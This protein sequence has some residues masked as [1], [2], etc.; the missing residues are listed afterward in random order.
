MSHRIV[1]SQWFALTDLTFVMLSGAIGL[2]YPEP[3]FWVIL[4]ALLPWGVRVLAGRFPFQRT[5]LDWPIALFLITAWVGYW[6]AYDKTEA[7]NKVCFIVLSILLYY[8]LS[9]QPRRNLAWVGFFSFLIGLGVSVYF[10]L[11]NEFQSS[12]NLALGWRSIRPQVEWTALHPGY[13]SGVLIITSLVA[14]YGISK[15]RITS[16]GPQL[17]LLRVV[18]LSGLGFMVWMLMASI[19]RGLWLAIAGAI[20]AW[21]MWKIISQFTPQFRSFYSFLVI[22]LLGSVLIFVLMFP[23]GPEYAAT[24]ENYGQSTRSEL[25]L[26]GLQILKD[27]PVFGGGLSS[28][29]GLYSQYYLVIPSKFY[30]NTYNMFLDVAIE[31]GAIGGLAF[32]FIYLGSV[33]ILAR[34]IANAPSKEIHNLHWLSLFVLMIAIVHGLIYDYLYNGT[35]A[36]LL[37]FPVGLSMIGRARSAS[38]TQKSQTDSASK[39]NRLFSGVSVLVVV[40]LVLILLWAVGFDQIRAMYF[41]N[42][43]VVQMSK[44]ELADFPTGQWT[45]SSILPRFVSAEDSFHSALQLDPF[46]RTAKHRLGLIAMLRGDFESACASL[47]TALSQ[48]PNHRGIIKTLGYCYVWLGD[49]D[50][51]VSLL[52]QIPEA[53]HEMGVYVWW[54]AGQGRDDLSAQAALMLSKLQAAVE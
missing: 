45:E 37:F 27:V 41:S 20:G 17:T 15:I 29:A 34:F 46:N 8:A 39:T 14:I 31:Q 26:R 22:L 42:L 33:W 50:S 28:F 44:A 30:D 3:G 38:E 18:F 52:A 6:S 10:I 23:G 54:W 4:I 1:D 43:G 11:T 9:G 7:W 5:P 51:A 13:I 21:V 47:Q 2:M 35:G 48:T 19:S 12:S 25:F 53:D 16:L 40:L 36:F 49:L 24:G 32:L